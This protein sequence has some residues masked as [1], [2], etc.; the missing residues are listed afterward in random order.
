MKGQTYPEEAVL[1]HAARIVGRPVKWIPSRT[2]AL[3]GDCH[4]RDQIVDAELALD[5]QGRF[6][7]LRWNGAHDAGA[8][9]AQH[10]AL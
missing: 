3:L 10:A 8:Y 9:L 4:A 5:A 1:T 6:L 2:E 7:A